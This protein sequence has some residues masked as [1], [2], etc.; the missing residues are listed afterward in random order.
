MFLAPFPPECLFYR[1]PNPPLDIPALKEEFADILS[2][3]AEMSNTRA[4]KVVRVRSERHAAL[5]LPDFLTFFNESWDFVVKCE[6]LCRRMIVGLRGVVVTQVCF[7]AEII[8]EVLLKY[9]NFF[10]I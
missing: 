9:R 8:E 6:V 4:A 7:S 5:E 10:T 1:S 2:S 3:A